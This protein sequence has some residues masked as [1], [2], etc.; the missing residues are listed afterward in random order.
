MVHLTEIEREIEHARRN[1][2]RWNAEVNRLKNQLAERPDSPP[3]IAKS[4][5]YE[6]D[7]Y[8]VLGVFKTGYGCTRIAARKIKDDGTLG[9]I[10]SGGAIS[11][12]WEDVKD[13]L[14]D[15]CAV[16]IASRHKDKRKWARQFLKAHGVK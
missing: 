16:E 10:T 13:Y 4:I 11:E 12:N 6:Y 9:A 14:T 15:E 8:L 7:L 1:A 2:E 5:W 3:R